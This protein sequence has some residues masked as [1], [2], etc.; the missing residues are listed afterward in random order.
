M[1]KIWKIVIV[2]CVML[3]SCRSVVA[4]EKD[5]SK[6]CL[7]EILDRGELIVGTSPDFPPNEFVDTSKKGDEQYVGSD[8]ELAK[9]I[10]DSLGVKLTLKISDFDNVLANLSTGQ[11]D[12]AISGLAYTPKRAESMELSKGY[13]TDA[14]EPNCHGLLI[15]VDQKDNYKGFE[16]FS[17]LKIGAQSGSIQEQYAKDQIPG[18]EIV[19]IGALTDGIGLMQTGNLDAISSA[20]TTGKEFANKN[21]GLFM[22]D[23][24]FT[25]S[26]EYAGTRIGMP[27]GETNLLN[28]VN[29]I[30]D[31]VNEKD[32]YSSWHETYTQYSADMSAGIQTT[33]M[34]KLFDVLT[35]NWQLFLKGLMMTL[36]LA[37]ITVCF[38]TLFGGLFALVKLSKNKVVRFLSAAYVEIIRGTPLLLQLW[39][40]IYLLPAIFHT[41][42]PTYISV[43]IALIINSSAYVAEIIRS[44]IQAVDKGQSEAAKSLGM[45][46]LHMMKR[47][48]FPQA[49]KN[50][51]PAL[52]NEFIMMVKET[53]L[54][55]TFFMGELM[56]VSKTIGSSTYSTIQP[57]IIV[58]VIYFLV[59]F[60]LSKAVNYMEGRMS[61][62]D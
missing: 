1:K 27:K 10:A 42:I 11:I 40:F 30:I 14:S 45:S 57:L 47:I 7:Q 33:F 56:T 8:I 3:I 28:K 31:E 58:G 5:G 46:N 61:V 23:I 36:G 24:E 4:E 21:D 55:S 39:L 41:N 6:D 48:I 38:G 26:E 15:P 32:L 35:D 25:I 52:G 59:T 9:Y 53:S 49:I 51:L 50:I 54:A 20:C 12:L 60:T 43:I 17:G 2:V 44:G 18:A 29:E 34:G 13:Y 19:P 22:S 62:S 37:A 16:D